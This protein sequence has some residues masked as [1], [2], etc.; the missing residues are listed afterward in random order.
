MHGPSK[1]GAFEEFKKYFGKLL[2]P[3]RRTSYDDKF[4]MFQEQLRRHQQHQARAHAHARAQSQSQAPSQKQSD[5]SVGTSSA[6]AAPSHA[7]SGSHIQVHG[8]ATHGSSALPGGFPT[9]PS[10]A[11]NAG[12]HSRPGNPWGSS[13]SGS[14]PVPSQVTGG[15][16]RPEHQQHRHTQHQQATQGQQYPTQHQPQIVRQQ[17]PMNRHLG[18]SNPYRS[19]VIH[20]AASQAPSRA[21]YAPPPSAQAPGSASVPIDVTGSRPAQRGMSHSGG[22]GSGHI[23][24]QGPGHTHPPPSQLHPSHQ[25]HPSGARPGVPPSQ[26]SF[27]RPSTVAPSQ[28]G[29]A[30]HSHHDMDPT[31]SVRVG[32]P[33]ALPGTPPQHR[34]Y[35]ESQI[36]HSQHMAGQ[37]MQ[38]QQQQLH[39]QQQQ[40]QQRQQQQR[41][42]QQQQQQ[43]RQHQHQHMQHP[44][45]ARR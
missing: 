41:Q 12:Q 15:H 16:V 8:H 18:P 26:L 4:R 1:V 37:S 13:T 2:T 30:G 24:T 10:T 17:Q 35:G 20:T 7:A 19:Q 32:G 38:Q 21:G 28:G 29:T 36:R 44:H 40:Q 33:P 6:A 23:I 34:P 9:T 43:L 3:Y 39:I 14:G 42:Q 31:G 27:A 22:S 25:S 5:A 45:Q 11:S